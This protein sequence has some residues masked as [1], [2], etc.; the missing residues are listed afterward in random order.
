M[1]N[2]IPQGFKDLINR[3]QS[4]LNMVNVVKDVCKRSH[5]KL[6]VDLGEEEEILL[7]VPYQMV[8]LFGIE[9]KNNKLT[10]KC[11]LSQQ[12]NHE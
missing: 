1:S 9:Y 5:W 7:T 11:N 6:S 10:D 3:E 2:E 8:D 4:K 12:N